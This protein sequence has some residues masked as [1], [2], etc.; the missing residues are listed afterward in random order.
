MG[1]DRCWGWLLA[2]PGPVCGTGWPSRPRSSGPPSR[3]WSSTRRHRTPPASGPLSRS[4]DRGRQ[5]A[6][7]RVGEPDGDRGPA[8]RHPG[9]AR[10]PR[11]RRRP[12]V[13]EP[14]AAA[15][16]RRPPVDQAVEEADRDAGPL[17]PD[18]RDRRR[19]GRQGTAADAAQG[20]RAVRRSGGGWPTSTR[21]RS[22]P[23]CPRPPGWPTPSRP[24]GRRSSS[25]SP[26]TSP[27]PAPKG[28]TGSSNRSSGSAADT[29]T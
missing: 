29:A 7:G 18:Q 9:A 16:R 27:T 24:G 12:G 15:H 6:P 17:R 2:A 13:G 5:V 14:A 25:P 20:A 8:T 28:S 22:T 4:V 26:T 21:P 23:S 10:P 19:L 11:H 1:R 3:S